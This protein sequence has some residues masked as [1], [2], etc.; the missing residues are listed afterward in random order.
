MLVSQGLQEQVI[1]YSSDLSFGWIKEERFVN[2]TENTDFFF[3]V[4]VNS[5]MD[6]LLRSHQAAVEEEQGS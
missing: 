4:V 6:F 2:K 5:Y 1:C 3:Y